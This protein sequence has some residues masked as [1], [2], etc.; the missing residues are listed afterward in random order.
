MGG[1]QEKKNMK[2]NLFHTLVFA[3]VTSV[4]TKPH[5]SNGSKN[6]WIKP[7]LCEYKYYY[8]HARILGRREKV[9][10][11]FQLTKH[12]SKPIHIGPMNW[13]APPP[14]LWIRWCPWAT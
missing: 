1:G 4:C 6:D 8:G 10:A 2:I 3:E 12:I 7:N 11:L 13:H 14:P 5:N 9:E